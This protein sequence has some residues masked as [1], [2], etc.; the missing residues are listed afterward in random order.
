[1]CI[2][3]SSVTVV[4]VSF[5][6]KILSSFVWNLLEMHHIKPWFHLFILAFFLL[7]LFL[8]ENINKKRCQNVSKMSLLSTLGMSKRCKQNAFLFYQHLSFPQR[9]RIKV[10][11][12]GCL[13][14]RYGCTIPLRRLNNVCCTLWYIIKTYKRRVCVW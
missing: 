8:S 9:N 10:F 14:V 12:F 5:K 3:D 2:R 11:W 1:M 4:T 6:L 13:L 7:V